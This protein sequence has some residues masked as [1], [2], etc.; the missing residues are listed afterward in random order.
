MYNLALCRHEMY[1]FRTLVFLYLSKRT[2][3]MLHAL[4]PNY[5][6]RNVVAVYSER[7]IINSGKMFM[8]IIYNVFTHRMNTFYVYIFVLYFM[9]GNSNSTN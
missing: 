9:N 2:M 5:D 4:C 6:L 3:Q 1:L 8:C 7:V